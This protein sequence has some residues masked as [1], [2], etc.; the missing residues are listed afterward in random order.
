MN[1]REFL[2]ISKLQEL[3]DHF[4]KTTGLAAIAIDN[5]GKYLT[6]ASNFTEFCSKY[7]RGNREGLSK[8]VECDKEC[9]GIYT[10]HAG[11]IE[12]SKEICIDGECI[13]KIIGGQVFKAEPNEDKFR[14][15]AKEFGL[16]E[17]GYIAAVRAVPIKDEDYIKTASEF[18]GELVNDLVNLEYLKF[19]D[20][21]RLNVITEELV[22]TNNTVAIINTKTK[23]LDSIAARQNILALNASIEAARAG[24]SGVGFAVVAKQMG[25]LSKKSASIYGEI[26]LA[27]AAISD[28]VKKMNR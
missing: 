18:L 23:E 6:K 4:A 17:E 3:Q 20:G 11:L 26:N 7:T 21:T 2:D 12:F 10:C 1:I 25:E 16:K 15:Q 28:S 24:E 5:E 22:K 9:L 27:S 13:G 19:Y 14:R 8:C